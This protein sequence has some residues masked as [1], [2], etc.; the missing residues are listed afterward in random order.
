MTTNSIE[1]PYISTLHGHTPWEIQSNENEWTERTLFG[2]SP[3]TPLSLFGR[4]RNT[5]FDSQFPHLPGKTAIT[6][7]LNLIKLLSANINAW[8]SQFNGVGHAP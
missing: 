7:G 1:A 6:S 4:D 5:D 8:L 3:P 2:L